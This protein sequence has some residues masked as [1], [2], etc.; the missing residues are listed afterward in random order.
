MC[1]VDE[2]ISAVH[3]FRRAHDH[4]LLSYLRNPQVFDVH[5]GHV[6]ALT[7]VGLGIEIDEDRVREA[8]RR[9]H[10]WRNPVWRGRDGS[11]REW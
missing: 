1:F 5:E 8:A 10:A 2:H 3:A 11:I 6:E 9:P 7:G 4:D